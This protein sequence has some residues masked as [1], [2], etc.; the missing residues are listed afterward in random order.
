[1]LAV[2]LMSMTSS[3]MIHPRFQKRRRLIKV[4]MPSRHVGLIDRAESKIQRTS[5]H[6]LVVIKNRILIQLDTHV[7]KVFGKA[8]DNETMGEAALNEFLHALDADVLAWSDEARQEIRDLLEIIA[9]E[10][11][12]VSIESL[13]TYLGDADMAAMVTQANKRSSAWA[14]QRIGNLIT[15]VSDTT[16]N[17]INEMTAT[18]IEEGWTNRELATM[19]DNAWEFGT[20]RSMLIAR[21]EPTFAETAGTLAGYRESGVVEGKGWSGEDP[22]DECQGNEEDGIIPLDDDFS[23]GD[24]GPPAHPKCKCAVYAA[25]LEGE[26]DDNT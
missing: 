20:D 8:A 26:S 1:L 17:A 22:C 4:P 16:R 7:G 13:A 12:S 24:D 15:E 2:T 6:E 14:H 3:E 18:A 19:I 9:Q 25:V 21:T 10:R 23:S 11:A 5:S